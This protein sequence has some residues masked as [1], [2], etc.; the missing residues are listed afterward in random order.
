[1]I[2]QTEPNKKNDRSDSFVSDFKLKR[3]AIVVNQIKCTT[4]ENK[5]C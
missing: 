4:N 5:Q 1:M 2:C 3:I